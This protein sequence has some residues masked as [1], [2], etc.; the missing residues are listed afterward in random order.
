ME[1]SD[2][3]KC[4]EM[5]KDYGYEAPSDRTGLHPRAGLGGL[6]GARLITVGRTSTLATGLFGHV[7][8]S[9]WF[10]VI[11]QGPVP[12]FSLLFNDHDIY[13][14]EAWACQDVPSIGP[15]IWIVRCVF[16]E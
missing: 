1:G 16:R 11:I 12:V 3:P 13:A 9:L 2:D 15:M 10:W 7:N 8:W 4:R 5:Y 6:V 14:K